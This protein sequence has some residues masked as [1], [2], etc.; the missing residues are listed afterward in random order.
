MIKCNNCGKAVERAT[1]VTDAQIRFDVRTD[2]GIRRATD[3]N[4]DLG[5]NTLDP[6]DPDCQ[7]HLKMTC[8]SCGNLAPLADY[9][10]VKD[11]FACRSSD[12][13]EVCLYLNRSLC[14]ACQGA[15]VK[16]FCPTCDFF[17]KCK[18]AKLAEM[19]AH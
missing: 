13:V 8:P 7:A 3:I 17:A 1:V 5:L 6:S 18:L 12:N 15:L 10:V 4:L 9:Q 11:C 19:E 14:V 2:N 16:R